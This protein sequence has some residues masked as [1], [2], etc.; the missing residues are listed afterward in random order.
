MNKAWFLVALLAL[1]VFSRSES[2]LMTVAKDALEYEEECESSE[3]VEVNEVGEETTYEYLGE[4]ITTAYCPCGICCGQYATGYTA[5][6]TIA[7]S[8]HTVACGNLPIGTRVMIDGV[9]YTVEDTGV[10][11]EWIDIFFDS[12][13]EALAYGMQIKSVY[14]VR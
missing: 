14:M 13:D 10:Y 4:W 7:T 8:Y 3:D 11:G 2:L 9:I 12:H 5:S 6:G 1:T